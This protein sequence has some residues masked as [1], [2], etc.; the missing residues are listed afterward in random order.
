MTDERL[1][2]M[3]LVS[4]MIR[5]GALFVISLVALGCTLYVIFSPA[6]E[7]PA[8]RDTRGGIPVIDLSE[9]HRTGS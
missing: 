3:L 8:M 2:T 1:K 7:V 4:T 6:D 9:T 5:N